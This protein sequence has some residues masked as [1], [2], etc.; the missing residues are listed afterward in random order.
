MFSFSLLEVTLL[1]FVVHLTKVLVHVKMS[2][3]IQNSIRL[4]PALF[5]QEKTYLACQGWRIKG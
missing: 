2:I 4:S 1:F 3:S 5:G